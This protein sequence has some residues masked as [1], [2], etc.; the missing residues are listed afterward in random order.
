M[1]L[2]NI[3]NELNKTYFITG[4]DSPVY[5]DYRFKMLSENRMD[6]IIMVDIR[7]INGETKLYYDITD[8]ANLVKLVSRR[9]LTYEELLGLTSAMMMVSAELRSFLL[10]ED[11]ISFEP[12]MI[13]R[14]LKTGNY[15]FICIPRLVDGEGEPREDLISLMEL[16]I[17]H[18]EATDER[19]VRAAYNVY[20][21]VITGPMEIK[22]IN[23]MVWEASRKEIDETESVDAEEDIPEIFYEDVPK[24]P[25]KYRLSFREWC[26]IGCTAVGLIF[27][28]LSVYLNFSK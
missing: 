17:S 26:S 27:V 4:S 21:A 25:H 22:S 3:K 6:G 23:D 14:D 11:C 15:E 18:V 8:K 10:G 20:Q 7:V 12:D 13:F 5:N 1:I 2:Y 9:D 24:K 28:G 16:I 19:A